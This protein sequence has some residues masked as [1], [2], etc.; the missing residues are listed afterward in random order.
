MKSIH[1]DIFWIHVLK[2][3]GVLRPVTAAALKAYRPPFFHFA[4]ILTLLPFAV[5]IDILTIFLLQ[6]NFLHRR[7]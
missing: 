1:T 3:V 6:L 4:D 2:L 5:F 7:N